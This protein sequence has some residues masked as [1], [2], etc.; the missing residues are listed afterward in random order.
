MNG[1]DSGEM[2]TVHAKKGQIERRWLL[3][4]AKD[5]VLGR[6]ASEVASLLRGKRNP[7]FTPHV[8]TGEFVVVVNAE[9]VRLTGK[10][11]ENKMYYDHSGHP[12]G[13]RTRS[14]KAVL[15]TKPTE[16]IRRAVRGMLPK[17][18]LGYQ[19]IRKL[20]IYAGTDHPHQAQKPEQ[21]E[22]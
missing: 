10:K 18:P 1:K 19:M 13:L 15:E 14:A 20:K 11:L 7:N 16:V 22:L 12:S 9:K 2:K 3:L 17:G 21:I 5:Q 4:D 8:D 6:L